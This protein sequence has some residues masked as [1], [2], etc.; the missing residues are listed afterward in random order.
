MKSWEKASRRGTFFNK[1]LFTLYTPNR[2]IGGN[3][4]L[5]D[6]NLST[7]ERAAAM[8]IAPP[9]SAAR[10][11]KTAVRNDFTGEVQVIRVSMREFSRKV[12]IPFQHMRKPGLRRVE[13]RVRFGDVDVQ[14]GLYQMQAIPTDTTEIRWSEGTTSNYHCA[15]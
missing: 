9:P 13:T 6:A 1:G 3:Q 4:V 5:R 11:I 2:A 14:P 8:G 7:A 12:G 15:M 10:E